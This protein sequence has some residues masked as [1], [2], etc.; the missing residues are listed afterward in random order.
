MLLDTGEI[1]RLLEELPGWR[2]ERGALTREFVFRDFSDAFRFM[3]AA[4]AKA[5]EMN[6]HPDWSNSYNRVVVA[7]R[8]HSVGGVTGL[9]F[10]LARA[11]ARLAVADMEP[12]AA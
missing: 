3:T 2:L 7:L 11:M 10:D 8:T 5:E 12:P 9:D 6:H 4:A 1:E